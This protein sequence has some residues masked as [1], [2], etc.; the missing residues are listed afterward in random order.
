MLGAD[1]LD[2][3]LPC[4]RQHMNVDN[5]QILVCDYNSHIILYPLTIERGKRVQ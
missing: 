2:A 1:M 4:I 5:L 3:L